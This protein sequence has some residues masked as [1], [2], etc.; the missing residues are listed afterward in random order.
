MR[1]RP[2]DA[3]NDNTFV[4]M[5]TFHKHYDQR[6]LI[7]RISS[8]RLESLDFAAWNDNVKLVQKKNCPP[9]AEEGFWSG[10]RVSRI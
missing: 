1:A 4:R 10:A 5:V 7:C 3:V 2:A 6:S 8:S 9:L